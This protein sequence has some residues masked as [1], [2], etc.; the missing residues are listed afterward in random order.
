MTDTAFLVTLALALIVATIGAAIAV[1]LGQSAILGYVAAGVLIGPYTAGPIADASTVAALADVGLVFLLFAV[2]L[3]LSIRDLLRVRRIAF[4][5]GLVQ[6]A[7]SVGLGYV[8]RAGARIHA[9]RGAVLR[10]LH[11]PVLEHGNR[12]NPCRARR[13]RLAT[14]SHCPWL[15]RAPGPLDRR[16]RRA[17]DGAFAGWRP[18]A[19]CGHCLGQGRCCSWR[20]AARRP[21]RPAAARSSAS[22]CCAAARCS[23]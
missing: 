23:Y 5:G 9:H 8:G 12:Q 4:V 13:A 2:G 1:R 22:L 3:E 14:R 17:T 6:V 21:F 20:P 10:C 7:A 16:P 11:Q 15:D 18:D 19:R